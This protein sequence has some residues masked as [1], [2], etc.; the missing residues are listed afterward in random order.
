MPLA[1][2]LPPIF[3]LLISST[4]TLTDSESIDAYIPAAHK[5]L[6]S[7]F[8]A[9]VFGDA[10]L[11]RAAVRGPLAVQSKADL[12]DFDVAAHGNCDKDTR[13]LVVGGTLTA[14]MGA[15]NS[16]YTVVGRRSSIHHT[17]RLTC[18]SRV[19]Q[20]DPARNGD[21]NFVEMRQNVLKE[22]GKMCIEE[23]TGNVE[24]VNSTMRFS[25]GEKGFSCYTYFKITTEDLRLVNRWE[26]AGD[27]F[28]RNIIIVVSG[29]KVDLKDF[30]MEGFNARRTLIV[31]CA[32]YG[33]FGVYNA[34]L[35]GSVLAPTASFTTSNAI[36]N[37]SIIVGN[38]R[39]SLATLNTPYVTC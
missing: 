7:S 38:L 33:S 3:L 32:V 20:Y 10:S 26:Y 24:L 8:N 4:C 22:T 25:L 21:I 30:E 1:N 29:V 39:G 23:P 27:D 19:E 12:A 34:K 28:F 6:Y 37:G 14:R 5:S 36:F 13:A 31:F 35:H 2:F 15:V 9:L 16:G 17:V 18:T 11:A